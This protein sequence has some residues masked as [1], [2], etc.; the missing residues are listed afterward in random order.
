MNNSGK[1]KLRS[2]EWVEAKK[3]LVDVVAMV[4]EDKDEVQRILDALDTV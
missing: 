3:Q 2:D 4:L 1:R